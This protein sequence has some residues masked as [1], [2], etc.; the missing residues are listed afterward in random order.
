[1]R[2]I[3]NLASARSGV[4]SQSQSEIANGGALVLLAVAVA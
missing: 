3:W 4:E 1:M 2:S